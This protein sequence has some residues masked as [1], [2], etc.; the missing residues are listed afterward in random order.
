[1]PE[2]KCGCIIMYYYVGTRIVL[3]LDVLSPS[4]LSSVCPVSDLENKAREAH[5]LWHT[6]EVGLT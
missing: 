4:C 2:T 1:M 5:I 6:I 3:L